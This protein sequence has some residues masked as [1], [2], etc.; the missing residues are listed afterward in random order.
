ML[1]KNKAQDK[2]ADKRSA[3][4]R[5]IEALNNQAMN[6]KLAIT[7]NQVA[8]YAP[9]AR[10]EALDRLER[11]ATG[12]LQADLVG[13]DTGVDGPT[14][15]GKVSEAYSEGKAVRAADEL[16]RATKL[17]SLMGKVAAPADLALEQSYANADANFA[18]DTVNSDF[19]GNVENRWLAMDAVEP[20]GGHYWAADYL[21]G[22]G[23]TIASARDSDFGAPPTTPR[24]GG[25]SQIPQ[26]TPTSVRTQMANQVPGAR[27]GV[28]RA[29][30]NAMLGRSPVPP[31]APRPGTTAFWSG[32]R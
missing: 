1:V 2:A 21:K 27:T 3:I 10:V 22:A 9:A 30:Q 25:A 12:R 17:A 24:P 23:L 5:E 4:L 16:R 15:G 19:R 8:S 14:Y 28:N 31:G 18:R 29:S 13:P 7:Q 11:Q 20:N 6:Q 32:G 26:G